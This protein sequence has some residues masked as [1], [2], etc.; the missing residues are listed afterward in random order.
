MGFFFF[1]L[2]ETYVKPRRQAG[3]R[4]GRQCRKRRSEGKQ[5][6]HKI[7]RF[8]TKLG[9]GEGGEK[10]KRRKKNTYSEGAREGKERESR[11]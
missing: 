5:G 9:R 1:V 3:L 8:L 4:A 2:I 11:A 6:D 7:P 10:E